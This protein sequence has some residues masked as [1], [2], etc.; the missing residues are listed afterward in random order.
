[1]LGK[2][3]LMGG[4]SVIITTTQVQ[5]RRHPKK[6]I[7]K[8]WL[9]QYGYSTSDIQKHGETIV[10]QEHKT[11]YMSQATYNDLKNYLSV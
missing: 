2:N 8:K 9:K 5:Q 6:R 11:M 1:M 10:D 7:N 3:D 4:Y